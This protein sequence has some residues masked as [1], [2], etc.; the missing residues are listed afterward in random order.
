[1]RRNTSRGEPTH[2]P[3]GGRQ[4]RQDSTRASPK[5]A[6]GLAA[7]LEASLSLFLSRKKRE[8]RSPSPFD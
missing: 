6:D 2:T 8:S 7:G 4:Q 3:R 5:A 1:M